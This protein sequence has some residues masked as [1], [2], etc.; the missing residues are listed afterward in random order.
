M[1]IRGGACYMPPVGMSGSICIAWE[2]PYPRI[3]QRRGPQNCDQPERYAWECRNLVLTLPLCI[4]SI[5]W[6]QKGRNVYP[7]PLALE[8]AC[9]R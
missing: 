5:N 2:P 6:F 4:K 9:P 7:T 3:G 1:A 8:I